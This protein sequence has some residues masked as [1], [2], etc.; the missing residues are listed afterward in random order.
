[1][2]KTLLEDKPSRERELKGENESS[3]HGFIRT[4]LRSSRK[5]MEEEKDF[6]ETKRE[7][8]GGERVLVS[9]KWV[10]GYKDSGI[11]NS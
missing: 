5:S 10:F 8:L 2:N 9:E 6:G 7:L 11:W 1:M 3:I 4:K